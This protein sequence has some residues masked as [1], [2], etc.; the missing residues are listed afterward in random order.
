MSDISQ[1]M[2]AEL[3]RFEKD[4]RK[5]ASGYQDLGSALR[6]TKPAFPGVEQLTIVNKPVIPRVIL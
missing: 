2:Y 3:L 5:K 1:Q 4:S 6:R